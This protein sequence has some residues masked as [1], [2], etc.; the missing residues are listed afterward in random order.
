MDINLPGM[1]GQEFVRRLKPLLPNTQFVMLTVYEDSDHI[2]DALQ[3]G[4]TGYLLKHTQRAGLINAL[5]EV[6][7]GGSP[8][9][10]NIARKVVKA[11]HHPP[12][13]D[14]STADLSSRESEV[15]QLLARGYLYKEIPANRSK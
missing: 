13:S 5:R 15:L 3:S 14:P 12:V 4:A 1:K 10:T 6:N 9:T 7:D 8:M 2:V 11:F